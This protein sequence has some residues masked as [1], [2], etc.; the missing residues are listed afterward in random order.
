M[1]SSYWVPAGLDYQ[2]Y[3]RIMNEVK[4]LGYNVIRLPFSNE[5]VEINP[6]VTQK[7]MA[8]PQ[9]LGM[10]AMTVLDHIVRYARRIGLKI[11]LDD[12]RSQ[13]ARPKRVNYL[14]E[15]LWYSK[16]FPESAWIDDWLALASR[17][18]GN[19]AVIGFDL[20]NEPHTNGPGP[21][22]LKAY[23]SRGATWG[24]Y[25][26]VD[27]PATDWRLAA[28]RAGNAVLAAN[29]HLV[30]FV[31]GVQ[32]YPNPTQP[33][34]VDQYFWSGILTPIR[35]YPVELGVRNQLVY[36]AHDWGP[37]KWNFPWFHHMA[38]AALTNVWHQHW[39]FLLD[40]PN[41]AN[42]TPV[43]LGEFGTCTNNPRCVDDQRPDNQATWFHF[44]LRFLQQHPEVGWGFFAL[45]GT[46]SNDS[47]ADNGLLNAKWNGVSNRGLQADLHSIQ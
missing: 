11:I 26:G 1:D 10:H 28:E 36:E 19:T 38:Y 47:V 24:P 7:V 30:I 3:K 23:L 37:W 43:W 41:A 40:D 2:P 17:Y 20:R 15:A 44:L 13:A 33:N 29:P 32:L 34:G 31:E 6:V 25:N 21:W 35:Q 45:N 46:N 5:L 27:D 8:N 16:R 4:S 12:A 22:T 14:D 18:K 39:A 42:A 9:F